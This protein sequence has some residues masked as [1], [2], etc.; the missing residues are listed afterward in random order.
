VNHRPNV[1]NGFNFNFF[2]K[3]GKI[4][5]E[6][7]IY[8]NNFKIVNNRQPLKKISIYK[9]FFFV[10]H[11][12]QPLL[13]IPKNFNFRSPVTL[14]RYGVTSLNETSLPYGNEF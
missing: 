9:I 3:Q 8:G 6:T 2:F 4:F 10:V 7:Q 12:V 11:N 5:R 14:S 1:H 13:Q